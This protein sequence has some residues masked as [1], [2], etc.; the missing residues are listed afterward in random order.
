MRIVCRGSFTLPGAPEI[1]WFTPEG[2]R[3]WVEGWD[4]VYCSGATDEP[5]AVWTTHG[6]T[7]WVTTDR[8]PTRVRYARVGANGTAGTVEVVCAPDGAGTE[9]TVT[10][11]LTATEPRG[12][13]VLHHLESGFAEM[14]ADWQKGVSRAAG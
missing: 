12:R 13:T 4:P 7:T 14:L 9:V 10:Y 3:A 1:G 6:D 8:T 11:D 2:E 5:G